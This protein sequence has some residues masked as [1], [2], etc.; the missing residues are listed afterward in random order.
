MTHWLIENII[1]ILG[2]IEGGF[3]AYHVYF[4]S[5][6]FDLKDKLLQKEDIRKQVEP[7]LHE[8]GKGRNSNVELVN[9][10]K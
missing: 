9:V 2:I 3:I 5:K 8:I 6:R 7:I 1:G 4:L 10:K